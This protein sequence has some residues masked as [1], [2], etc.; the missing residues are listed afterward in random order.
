MDLE[1]ELIDRGSGYIKTK[2][3]GS[4]TLDTDFSTLWWDCGSHPERV[5]PTSW[6]TEDVAGRINPPSVTAQ[7]GLAVVPL[8]DGGTRLR[9]TTD[10]VDNAN[11]VN[12]TSL[13]MLEAD[14]LDRI[15]ARWKELSGRQ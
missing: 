14:L 7:I 11:R 2:S 10:P 1:I 8:A 3:M 15:V 5:K 4:A 12:C 9:V 13:G 6:E